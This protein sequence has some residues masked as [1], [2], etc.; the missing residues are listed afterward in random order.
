MRLF[1]KYERMKLRKVKKTIVIVHKI[2]LELL[3]NIIRIMILDHVMMTILMMTM[4][5]I[6]LTM[7]RSLILTLLMYH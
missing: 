1:A 4:M 3:N 6:I 2:I 7:T 5:M